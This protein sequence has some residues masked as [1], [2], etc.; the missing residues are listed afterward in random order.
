[1]QEF[2]LGDYV[3]KLKASDTNS[4]KAIVRYF[5]SGIFNFLSFKTNDRTAAEDLLQE[6]FIKLWETRQ[7]LD[8]SQSVKSYLFTI[9]NNLALNHIRHQKIVV[10]FMERASIDKV[11][12]ESPY[13]QLTHKELE[14]CVQQAIETMSDKVRIVFLMC[15]VEGLSYKE[16]A[17]RL[18]LSVATVESHMVKG[19]RMVREALDKY[20]R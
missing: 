9:A 20:N 15:K 6:T 5:H 3:R 4:F 2:D 7:R 10:S 17:E 11:A 8:E 13:E 1:M 16:I 19:L 14:E 12:A 18:H